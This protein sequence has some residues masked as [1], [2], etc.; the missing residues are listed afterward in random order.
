MAETIF[1]GKSKS[2]DSRGEA[3][4]KFKMLDAFSEPVKVVIEAVKSTAE[5]V[6]ISFD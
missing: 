6:G 1:E 5:V 3:D 2:E 4:D